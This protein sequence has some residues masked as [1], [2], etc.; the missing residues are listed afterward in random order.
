VHI[1]PSAVPAAAVAVGAS[2]PHRRWEFR[3]FFEAYH[4]LVMTRLRRLGIPPA[5]QNDVCQEVFVILHRRLGDYDGSVSLP[6]WVQTICDRAATR[7][8]R[9]AE[10]RRRRDAAAPVLR[11]LRSVP[12]SQDREVDT[13]RAFARAEA[14]L[15]SLDEEKRRVFILYELEG[16][17]MYEVTGELGCPLQTGYSRLR[18]ARKIIRALLL[19]S[20]LNPRRS[21]G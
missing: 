9:V 7:F 20:H 16:L 10:L 1:D 17:H 19:R 5:D 18:A 21:E 12:A 15:S 4:P 8:L 14:I 2:A 13:R 3:A 11:M 6:L